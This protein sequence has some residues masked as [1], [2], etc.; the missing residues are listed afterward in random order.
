[1]RNP[2]L[3]VFLLP[4]LAIV[5]QAEPLVLT[6]VEQI[7]ALS[8]EEAAKARPVKLRGVVTWRDSDPRP[9]FFIHDGQWNIWVDRS[10]ATARGVWH[11]G[12]IDAADCSI[13]SIVEIDAVTD[14]GGYAPCIVPHSFRRIGPGPLPEVRRPPLESL[15]S[16]REDGQLVEMEGV[17]QAISPRTATAIPG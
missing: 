16:G 2:V 4:G 13:G 5:C 8:R 15:L 7:R 3:H 17:V 10:T 11:G 14:P 9:S 12:E 6:K 1:M